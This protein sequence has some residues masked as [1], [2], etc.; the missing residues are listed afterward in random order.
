MSSQLHEIKKKI[1]G[2][3]EGDLE[4]LRCFMESLR[5]RS[6]GRAARGSPERL[7]PLAGSLTFDEGELQDILPSIQRSRDLELGH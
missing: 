6:S 3:P 5:E 7:L 1:E 2:L 4:E